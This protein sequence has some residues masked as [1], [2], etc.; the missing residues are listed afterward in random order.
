MADEDDIESFWE[1]L[2]P[3]PL[4]SDERAKQAIET[5][6][7]RAKEER[8]SR[9]FVINPT[10]F[11]VEARGQAILLNRLGEAARRRVALDVEEIRNHLPVQMQRARPL[12]LR[13]FD[14]EEIRNHLPE[15][16]VN[17]QSPV[18]QAIQQ[19]SR[20]EQ[21]LSIVEYDTTSLEIPENETLAE[22][23]NRFRE[24]LQRNVARRIERE[25]GNIVPLEDPDFIVPEA[26][27]T[28]SNLATLTRTLQAL[29]FPAIVEM[30]R[31]S[32]TLYLTF[33]PPLNTDIHLAQ[34]FVPIVGSQQ[35]E[36]TTITIERGDTT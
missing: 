3:P 1:G 31:D 27:S 2:R 28:E 10:T 6:L 13:T 29:G 26:A 22:V 36:D 19:E 9:P 20:V 30:S 16:V 24:A 7:S 4:S 12:L 35:Y 32:R 17:D 25:M 33:S 14:V 5:G 15:E 23:H 21:L 18:V 34:S 8:R 11:E